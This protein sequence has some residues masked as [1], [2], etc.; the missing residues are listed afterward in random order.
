MTLMNDGP[1]RKGEISRIINLTSILGGGVS[2]NRPIAASVA[3][4]P[5]HSSRR[6]Y[7][8]LAMSVLARLFGL[9]LGLAALAASPA[10]HATTF[11]T[12]HSFTAY[13]GSVPEAGLVLDSHGML[14][15]TRAGALVD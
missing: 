6:N 9:V 1:I 14:Y 7:G 12:L 8:D 13:D 11:T 10:A 15:G 5:N 4:E 3:A 2:E